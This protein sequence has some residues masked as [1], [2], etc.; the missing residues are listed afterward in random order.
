MRRSSLPAKDRLHIGTHDF[1][2]R[3]IVGTGKY[4]SYE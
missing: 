1:S 4:A 3:L 2:S